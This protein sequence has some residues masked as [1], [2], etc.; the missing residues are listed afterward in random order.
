MP[1]PRVDSYGVAR[2]GALYAGRAAPPHAAVLAMLAA[3]PEE[4]WVQLNA[5]KNTFDSVE[6]NVDLRAWYGGTPA[7]SE[8]VQGAWPSFGW[9]ST[10]HQLVMWGGGHANTSA[11]E[12]YVWRCEDQ[13]WH[14][15]FHASEMVYTGVASTYRSIDDITPVSSHTYGN[16]NYLPLLNRFVTLGGAAYNTGGSLRVWS[17]DTNLRPAGCYTL[18]MAQARQGKVAG[19]TGSN[20]KRGVYSGVSLDGANAWNLRDWFSKPTG[21]RPHVGGI[22]FSS[23]VDAGTAY[24]TR[25]GH[26]ALLYTAQNKYLWQVEFVDSDWNND[27]H[28]YIGPQGASAGQ[29]QGQ[30]AYDPVTDVVVHLRDGPASVMFEFMDLKR[31]WGAGN[32]WRAATLAASAAATEFQALS[33]RKAG[34]IYNQVKGCFT[35]WNM[36]RQVW[37]IYPP[38]GNPTPDGGWQIVK[39]V[40]DAG[41]APRDSYITSGSLTETGVLGKFRWASDLRASV[42]TFGNRAG[43]V[44]AYKPTGWTDPRAA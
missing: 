8:M 31:T 20:N 3:A 39:P 4:S 38:A 43:E 12:V 15:A 9:D 18:D 11:N 27:V 32:G 26:D 24:L 7:D 5:G 22:D 10:E 6:P 30:I 41:S 44:W 14:L 29:G 42:T 35:V 21:E 36:G 2:V 28:S 40:M 1:T 34:L 13:N 23:H 19:A 33:I 25:N 16:N 17:G 37:D